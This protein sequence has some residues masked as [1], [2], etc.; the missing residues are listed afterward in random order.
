MPKVGESELLTSM[1]FLWQE[2]DHIWE[3][4]QHLPAYELYVSA[5]YAAIFEML[6]KL[7]N[8]ARYFLEWGSG[9]GVVSIMAS[10]LGYEAYG[11]EAKS[12]LVTVAE[13]LAK[14][15]H[16]HPRFAT[17]SFIPNDFEEDIGSGIE[18]GR[19]L[20]TPNDAYDELDMDLGDFDLVYA[21][22]W[23]DEHRIYR[24][25]MQRYAANNSLYLRYDAREGLS[26]SRIRRR[27]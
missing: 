3:T 14:K 8:E 6:V 2:V 17:G 21:F 24:S 16:A 7:R 10:R 18:F 27:R 9:L 23:P 26:L 4:N 12:E 25:I 13:D 20:T 22:P 1:Q 11:I 15:Y 19:T 5:D